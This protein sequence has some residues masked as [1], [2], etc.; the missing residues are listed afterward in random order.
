MLDLPISVDPIAGLLS[1]ASLVV[2]LL[3][4]KSQ[5]DEDYKKKS[6]EALLA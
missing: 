1:L 6:L 4:W 2:T 3:M 5:R